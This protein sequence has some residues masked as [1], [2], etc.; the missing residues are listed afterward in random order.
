MTTSGN[1]R[2][3]VKILGSTFGTT[4]PC[5]YGF[6]TTSAD[7]SKPDFTLES[8]TLSVVHAFASFAHQDD[9]AVALHGNTLTCNTDE[10]CDFLRWYYDGISAMTSPNVS[11]FMN[12]NDITCPIAGSNGCRGFYFGLPSTGSS[13]SLSVNLSLDVRSNTFMA[14]SGHKTAF[15]DLSSSSQ[16]AETFTPDPALIKIHADKGS[17]N[18][19]NITIN[20]ANG[21][22]LQP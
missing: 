20:H 9:I 10:V 16:Y 19:C 13:V 22:P 6:F 14:G 2:G 1:A 17:C 4:T 5:T 8:S 21:Y 7:T 15:A 3:H 12:D 11:F 18:M